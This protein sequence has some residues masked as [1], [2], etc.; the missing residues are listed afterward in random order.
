MALTCLS[1][2]YVVIITSEYP[3]GLQKS[4]NN[5]L[6]LWSMLSSSQ[7]NLEEHQ[8]KNRTDRLAWPTRLNKLNFGYASCFIE[9][10]ALL[11]NIACCRPVSDSLAGLALCY[12]TWH[13]NAD[14]TLAGTFRI[15]LL[16]L[17]ACLRH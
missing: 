1:R 6:G 4:L 3:L 17:A 8:Q 12:V 2:D 7:K 15:H 14:L 16:H 13:D 5:P 9:N 11:I 10:L